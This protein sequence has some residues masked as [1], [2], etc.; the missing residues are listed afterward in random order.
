MMKKKLKWELPKSM[1]RKLSSLGDVYFVGGYVRDFLLTQV[2]DFHGESADY[3]GNFTADQDI[4][5]TDVDVETLVR[6]LSDYGRAELVGRSFSVVKFRYRGREYDFTVPS[7]RNAMGSIPRPDMSIED[8]LRGRDFT[9]NAIAF[10]IAQKEFIDPTGG[11]DDIK[12]GVL[13]QTN[14]NT[15]SD[16]PLRI[17]RLCRFYAHFGF[18]IDDGTIR[19]AEENVKNLEKIAGER[20]GAEFFKIMLLPHPSSVFRCFH[21]IGVLKVLLPELEDCIDVSQPGGMHAYDVF[22]HILK[23]VDEAPQDTLVR[24]A[25]LFHDISKPRHKFVADDG[26]ARFYGHQET[27]AKIAKKWLQKYSFSKKFSDDVAKLVRHHMFTHAQTDKGIR[28]FV[29]RVGEE[30]LEPLFQLRFADTKAQGI[31]GDLDAEI[32]YYNRVKNVMDEKPPLSAKD[33]A[34]NGYDVMNI[35][36]ISP[37]PKVGEIMEKILLK[38]IDDPSL[39]ERDNLIEMLKD[40]ASQRNK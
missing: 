38:V 37:S 24:F 8:D 7:V 40:M 27:S 22:N 15:F 11:I 31:G 12:R 19:S 16:D 13:R 1:L 10:D 5:V 33:L 20:I 14:Q 35:F 23:T 17:I 4:L 30:L 34:I 29:R 18:K 39:N 2:I 28:R 26:R 21:D 25:A 3:S 6:T 32:E 9:V 36:K